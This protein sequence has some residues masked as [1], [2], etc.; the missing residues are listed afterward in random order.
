MRKNNMSNIIQGKNNEVKKFYYS[1]NPQITPGMSKDEGGQKTKGWILHNVNWNEKELTQIIRTKSYITSELKDGYKTKSNVKKVFNIILDFDKGSPTFNEFVDIANRYK[2]AWVAHTTVSHRKPKRDKETGEEIPGT[3]VDKFRVIIPL[4]ESITESA[5]NSCLQ[6]WEK[7]YPSIDTTSFQGNRYFMVNP[8]A[9]VVF[10]NTY[11]D[12]DGNT[13]ETIFLDP[14]KVNMINDSFKKKP[15]GRPK[16]QNNEEL[17]N[18]GAFS[19]DDSVTTKEGNK[20]SIRDITEKT[21]I[22]CPFCDPANRQNPDKH[23]AFLNFN[24]AGQVYLYCSSENKTYWSHS[25]E[26]VSNKSSLFFNENLGYACRIIEDEED[27]KQSRNGYVVFKNNEDWKNYCHHNNVNPA[28]KTYLPRLNIIFDP[29]KPS[30]LQ[31]KYFNM[32]EESEYLRNHDNTASLLSENEVLELMKSKTPVIYEIMLNVLGKDEYLIRFLNWNAV[33]LKERSKVDTAWLITSKTQGIGKGLIFDRILQPIYGKHQSTLV[34]GDR[35]ANNFNSQDQTEWL[36]VYD[37]VYTAGN[38]KENLARKEWLK[39]IITAREQT[40]ELK[41]IDAF[42]VENHMN[43]ILYSN[44]ECPIFLDSQD[45]RFNVIRNENT[46]KTSEL[47]FYKSDKEMVEKIDNEL[48]VFADL[49]LRY[50]YSTELA[51][52]AINTEAKEQMQER[53]RDEC[54][55]FVNA[56]KNRDVEYFLLDEIFPPRQGEIEM[57]EKISIYGHALGSFI[58]NGEIPAQV[59]NKICSYHF[60]NI[61]YKQILNRLKQKGLE[62]A[63][64]R[65]SK[66]SSMAKESSIAIYR[67]KR[68]GQ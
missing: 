49:L 62:N 55:E 8:V 6:F 38:P 51:N 7:K 14:Y 37:E 28:C 41:G 34:Q 48:S 45:R 5:Y 30:G 50:E 31:E 15:V 27:R 40:I 57:G 36:R 20:I 11:I 26:L 53:A 60:K 35:I 54:E 22:I 64:K 25:H 59:L 9:E 19:I 42:Q 39:Y 16:L 24:S 65:F 10:H 58:R 46:K 23:N 68:E 21:Q 3:E 47:S 1:Y 56:L 2:F 17:T 61:N 33:I 32:F 63:T 4:K 66:E 67:V 13:Q 44:N 52:R 29:K 43:L 18:D 12:K